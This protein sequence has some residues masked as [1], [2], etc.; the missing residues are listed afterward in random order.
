[1]LLYTIID[2]IQNEKP[3]KNERIRIVLY[4]HGQ[5]VFLS[6]L[7]VAKMRQSV[8]YIGITENTSRKENLSRDLLQLCD[9]IKIGR[10]IRCC[11]QV[12]TTL[13]CI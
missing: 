11:F 7:T 4:P 3:L 13:A 2:W 6:V 10:A 1:M 8:A 5:N 12:G 9:T